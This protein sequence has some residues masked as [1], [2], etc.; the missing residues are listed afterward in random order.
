MGARQR[1][2][3]ALGQIR[4]RGRHWGAAVAKVTSFGARVES[5]HSLRG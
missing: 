4:M 1:G 3:V 5:E 2:V